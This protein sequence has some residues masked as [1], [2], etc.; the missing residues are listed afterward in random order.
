MVDSYVALDI[1]TTGLSPVSDAIIEVGAV[2]VENG[3][4]TARFE[5]FVNPKCPIPYKIT[6]I[7]GITDDMVCDALAVEDII[8]RVLDI[9]RDLPLLGH[10]IL[11][12]YSFIKKAALDCGMTF[13][14]SGIDTCKIARKL[15]PDIKSKSLE[16]LCEYFNIETRHHRALDDAVTAAAVYDRL[17]K[18]SDIENPVRQ[19]VYRIPKKNPI[20]SK[21]KSYL[22]SLIGRYEI[23]FDKDIN[24]LT[25]SEASKAIDAIVST[26]GIPKRV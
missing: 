8:E 2:R 7:T 10:N 18:I 24:A 3:I 13:E 12:D 25:K 23:Q 4:E 1:E 15:L 6:D 16:Y 21:Q 5:T 20:T 19:L 14:R 26:Y 11:F 17:R 9:T 22:K